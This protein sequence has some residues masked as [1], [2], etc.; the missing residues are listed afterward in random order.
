M[1]VYAWVEWPYLQGV[2]QKMG[3]VKSWVGLIMKC[4]STGSFHVKVNGGL[5]SSFYP[6]R[7]IR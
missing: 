4:V 1:K 2:M 5:L 7:G 3:F 6:S